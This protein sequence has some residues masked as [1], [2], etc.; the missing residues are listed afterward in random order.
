VSIRD[1]KTILQSLSEASRT[2]SDIVALT[3]QVRTSLKRKICYQLSEGR[4][5]LFVYQLDPEIEE[6]FRTSIRQSAAGPYL[7]MDPNTIQQVLDAAHAQIGNLPPTAQR[8]VILTDG[9]IRRFVKRLLE[10]N[11]PEVAV[12]QYEQLTPEITVQPLGYI[13]F[14]QPQQLS[15]NPSHE[16]GAGA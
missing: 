3:E 10:Y 13:S 5:T 6:A 2:D 7:S 9:D 14:V 16:L 8:P 12:L 1:L 11:H 15:G 4:A